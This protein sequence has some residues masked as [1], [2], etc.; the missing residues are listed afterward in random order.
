MSLN[1]MINRKGLM[2][3]NQ[4]SKLY[5]ITPPP[6]MNNENFEPITLSKSE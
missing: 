3:A 4:P 5:D 1:N 2:P 6:Y